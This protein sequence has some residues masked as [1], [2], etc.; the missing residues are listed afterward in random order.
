MIIVEISWR[1]Q[2]MMNDHIGEITTDFILIY[3]A[4]LEIYGLNLFHVCFGK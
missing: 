2:S 4:A 3:C 1:P